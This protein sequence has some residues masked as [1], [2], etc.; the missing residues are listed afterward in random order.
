MAEREL[1]LKGAQQRQRVDLAQLVVGTNRRVCVR[2]RSTLGVLLGD[3]RTGTGEQQGEKEDAHGQQPSP[4]QP[5][6]GRSG[7]ATLTPVHRIWRS[8]DI[9]FAHHVHGH[10]GACVNIHGHTWKLEV[11]AEASLLDAAPGRERRRIHTVI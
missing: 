8:V 9:S 1:D 2:C 7:D 4:E 10:S 3:R 5:L 11:C 6:A